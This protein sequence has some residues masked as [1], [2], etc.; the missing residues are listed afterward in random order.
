MMVDGVV[1][2]SGADIVINKIEDDKISNFRI[3]NIGLTI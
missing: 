3:T 1:F 2:R